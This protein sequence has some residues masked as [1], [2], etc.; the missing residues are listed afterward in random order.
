MFDCNASRVPVAEFDVH[1]L[2][3][4]LSAV[5]TSSSLCSLAKLEFLGSCESVGLDNRTAL[6][7]LKRKNLRHLSL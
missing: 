1:G 2:T 3:F 4:D 7:V 5:L 6:S